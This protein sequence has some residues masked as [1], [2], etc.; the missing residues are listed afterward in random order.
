[1]PRRASRRRQFIVAILAAV[2]TNELKKSQ[3][4]TPDF[5]SGFSQDID[6]V[7]KGLGK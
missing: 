1:M 5:T 4:H 7:K 2:G 3:K 6:A